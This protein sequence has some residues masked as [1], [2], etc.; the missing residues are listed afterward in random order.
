M[1]DLTVTQI[2]NIVN[3]SIEQ[4]TGNSAIANIQTADFVAVAQTALLTGTDDLAVGLSQVL[5]RTIYAVR[6]YNRQFRG[7]ERTTQEFG[8]HVRKINF[9]DDEFVNDEGYPIPDKT[10]PTSGMYD[11]NSV[12]MYTIRNPRVVQTNFYGSATYD[13]Y[14]TTSRNQIKKAFTSAGEFNAFLQGVLTNDRNQMEQAI[15]QLSHGCIANLIGGKLASD[16]RNVLDLVSLYNTEKGTTLTATTVKEPDNWGNFSRWAF[17]YIKTLIKYLG[18]RSYLYHMNLTEGNIAR[19]SRPSDL[20][21]WML[22]EFENSVETEVLSMTFNDEYLKFV[23]HETV[24]YWQALQNPD[25]ISVTASYTGTDG[26]VQTSTQTQSNIIGV[27]AD[28]DA[29]GYTLFNQSVDTTPFN[30]RGRYYN[31]WYNW[32]GRYYNDL[33]ENVI[34]LTLGSTSQG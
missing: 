32:E 12:D 17:G 9:I 14:R 30:A 20:H 34:V 19:Q 18:E 1:N 22:A 21:C 10:N 27:I 25:E 4:A 13:F 29:C 23:D 7:L 5:A 3:E 2:A 31:T 15:D 11:G 24:S 33:T 8:N 6:P 16:S 28:R 26:T